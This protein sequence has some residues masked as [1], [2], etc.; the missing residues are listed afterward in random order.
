MTKV[1]YEVSY[2]HD[3]RFRVTFRDV[4]LGWVNLERR[5][6]TGEEDWSCEFPAGGEAL[7]FASR[8]DAVRR[9]IASQLERQKNRPIPEDTEP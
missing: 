5:S 3:S 6:A 1:T 9:L 2:R 8:D 7:P 4:L